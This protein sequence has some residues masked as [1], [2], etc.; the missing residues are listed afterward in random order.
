MTD[1]GNNSGELKLNQLADLHKQVI[2]PNEV[3]GDLAIGKALR[4]YPT[5]ELVNNHNKLVLEEYA[6]KGTKMYTIKARDKIRNG[7]PKLTDEQIKAKISNDI[8][9]TAGIPDSITIFVGAKVMLKTNLDIA[10]KLVNG[11]IGNITE[12]MWPHFRRDQMYE[13]DIPSVRVNF[14]NGVGEHVIYTAIKEFDASGNSIAERYMLPLVLSWASTGHKMQGSTLNREVAYLSNHWNCKGLAYVILSRAR[15][16]Q[17]I[18]LEALN[19]IELVGT[20]PCNL[21]AKEEMER[22]RNENNIDN[23]EI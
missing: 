20:R 22:M 19:P 16:L 5:R 23:N 21:A 10:K 14:E 6:K 3:T 15:S 2:S 17:S 11:A 8:N 1:N 7:D 13:T 18:R 9:R 4:I 12:I